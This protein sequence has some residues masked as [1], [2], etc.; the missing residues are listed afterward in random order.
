MRKFFKE[1]WSYIVIIILVLFIRSTKL[2]GINIVSGES[3]MSTL[4]DGQVVLGSS[5]KELKRGDIIVAKTDKLVVKRIIGL[6]GETVSYHDG[7]LYIN[8]VKLEE[9]YI[10]PGRDVNSQNQVWEYKCGDNEY[11]ILGDN[12]DNSYDGR[13][14][15]PLS[16]DDIVEKVY[17]QF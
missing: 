2:I 6:P 10:E 15:G 3:M 1:N 5:L 17:I 8:G 11:L 14:Y 7:A 13:Y 9:E 4:H 12:R 16:E